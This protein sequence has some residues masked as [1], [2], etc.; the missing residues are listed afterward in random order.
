M[1]CRRAI[2]RPI[3]C[4]CALQVLGDRTLSA[5]ENAAFE[6]FSVNTGCQQF[7]VYQIYVTGDATRGKRVAGRRPD[8][9]S[10]REARRQLRVL[11]YNASEIVARHEAAKHVVD[12][13][14]ITSKALAGVGKDK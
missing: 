9:C 3:A 10:R 2:R 13:C 4:G 6:G 11:G 8:D 1:I 5:V 14:R 12:A 7:L